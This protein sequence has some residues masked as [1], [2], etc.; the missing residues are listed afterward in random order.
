MKTLILNRSPIPN[1]DTAFLVGRLITAQ[2][3]DKRIL[4]ACRCNISPSADCRYCWET[5]ICSIDLE[6]SC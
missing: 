2:D 6:I 5:D 4:S 1:G 3:R